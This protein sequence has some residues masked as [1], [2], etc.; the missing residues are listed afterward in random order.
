MIAI[1]EIVDIFITAYG[2]YL[3]TFEYYK[4]NKSKQIYIIKMSAFE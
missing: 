3:C 1:G 4:S 2:I